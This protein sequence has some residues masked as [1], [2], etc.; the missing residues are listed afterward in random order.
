[1]EDIMAGP[2]QFNQFTIDAVSKPDLRCIALPESLQPVR[3]GGWLEIGKSR[4]D[5]ENRFKTRHDKS[6]D[7][8]TYEFRGTFPRC[9]V[10][11]EGLSATLEVRYSAGKVTH[12][13]GRQVASC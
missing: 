10:D 9:T 2:D 3:V 7:Q 12:I 11:Y 6:R 13:S 8:S 5:V 4:S 1:M